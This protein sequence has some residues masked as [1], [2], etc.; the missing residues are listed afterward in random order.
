MPNA[1]AH[2]QFGRKVK[3]EANDKMKNIIEQYT[4]LFEIGVHGP[5]ILF[6]Y[7]PLKKDI[8]N[9]KGHRMHMEPAALFFEK[10]IQVIQNTEKSKRDAATAYIL[11]FLCHFALD[12]Q[13]H[14]YIET[15][16]RDKGISHSEL[17]TEFDKFL[18]KREGIDPFTFDYAGHIHAS[19]ENAR[20]IGPFLTF[21]AEIIVQSLKGMKKVLAYFLPNRKMLRSVGFKVLKQMGMYESY[22]GLFIRYEDNEDCK[23]INDVLAEKLEIA[24]PY[25][26]QLMAEFMASIESK[27]KYSL[28]KYFWYDY[29][30]DKSY[31]KSNE[32]KGKE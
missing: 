23:E 31:T 20:V 27:G 11:G 25:A 12:R 4:Q 13:C 30:T 15:Q 6:Y 14:P 3:L 24:I 2:L 8:H 17:E 26:L 21:P 18:L 19:K 5:D 7:K 1:Y 29:C 10:A 22:Q 28:S 9:Q 16:V 32:D